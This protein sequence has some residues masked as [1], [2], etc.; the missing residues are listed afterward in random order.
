MHTPA[1]WNIALRTN[2][3]KSDGIEVPLMQ[4]IGVPVRFEAISI[5]G[6]EDNNQMAIVPLDSS[7]IANARLIASAP[8][9]LA[10]LEAMLSAASAYGCDFSS[11]HPRETSA[12]RAAIAKAKGA[13]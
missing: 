3:Y 5:G 10:A 13:Q 1:P 4:K 2:F 9:L 7:S 12:A 8:E 11:N 6:G